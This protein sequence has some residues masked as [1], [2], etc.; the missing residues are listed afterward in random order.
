MEKEIWKE[1]PGFEGYYEVSNQGRVRSLDRKAW[2]GKC[3]RLSKGRVLN[4]VLTNGYKRVVLYSNKKKKTFSVHQ[5]IAIAFLSHEPC[6]YKIVVDHINNV[7]TDNRLENLQLISQR[8][9][10]SKDKK[11]CSSKYTG[12]SW[13]KQ[14]NKWISSIVIKG[15][16]KHLGYFDTEEEA[17]K[18]YQDALKAIEK[19]EEIKTKKPETSSKYKGVSFDKERNKW[20]SSAWINGKQKFLGRFKCETAAFLAY[21]AELSKISV[22]N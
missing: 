10:S 3:Y 11:G 6:G 8:E 18:Y 16:I 14:N 2:N 9:N 20:V 5:L 1:L 21:Q 19:G 15:K 7:K 17:N 12:V 22:E 4:P 13:K